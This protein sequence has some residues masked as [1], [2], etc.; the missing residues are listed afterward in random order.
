MI[1]YMKCDLDDIVFEHR[2]RAYGAYILRKSYGKNMKR[3]AIGGAAMFLLLLSSPLIA[4]KIKPKRLLLEEKSITLMEAPKEAK[5][6]DIPPPPPPPPPPPAKKIETLRFVPPVVTEKAETEPPVITPPDPNVNI[7]TKNIEG[8]KTTTYTPPVDVVAPA[9]PPIETPKEVKKVEED[10]PFVIVEQN[11]EFQDGVKAMYQFL[12][13]NIKYP[14]VA[15]ESA[16]EGTVYVGFV[17]GKDGAIRDV[18]VKRG[19]GGGC[20]EEAV[21]VVKLMPNWKPGKQQGKPV[22]V[23]YTI[24]IKFHLD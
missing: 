23:A 20:N 9:P 11:P 7:G 12:A 3:A 5:K 8:E 15:R 24:P 18:V 22:S 19:I 4:D 17:V 6:P 2:N 1:D 13:N 21:R 14:A 16:I 10:I